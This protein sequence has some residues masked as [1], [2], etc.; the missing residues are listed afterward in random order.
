MKDLKVII[1]AAGKGTRMNKGKPS[2]YP[3]ALY[4]ISNKPMVSYIINTLKKIG[5]KKPIL[6]I[7]YKADLVK[8]E[9]KDGCNYVLQK[10][11]LGTAHAARLG[12]E[13]VP[14]STK[15]ILILQADDSAF[16]K[17]KTL[18]SFIKNHIDKKAKISFLTTHIPGV[19]DI[20]RII[21]D[22][23][24]NVIKIVE[25]DNLTPKQEKIDEVN[26]GC[27]L[28]DA[29]WLKKNIKKIKRTYKGGKEYPLPDIIKIALSSGDKV[30]A[31]EIDR[32]E[33]KG[34]NT[35]EQLKEAE[36]S[37]YREGQ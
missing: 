35:L 2:L 16:Y 11:R 10:K 26:C 7:G 15:Y 32:S 28:A 31:Y 20:G 21:R 3:K 29:V 12:I 13:K 22:K 18:K 27:Y 4:P 24:N 8:K 1:L 36:F 34:V 9:F 37:L 30:V 6:I 23:N 25:K 14:F 17:P 33:W 5:I 19:K